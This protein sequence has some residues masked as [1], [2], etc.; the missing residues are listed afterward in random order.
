MHTMEDVVNLQIKLKSPI[1]KN[2]FLKSSKGEFFLVS[3]IGS[4]K[5]DMKSLKKQ[6]DVSDLRFASEEELDQYLGL[7]PGSVSIFGLI[8]L[9]VEKN[10]IVVLDSDLYESAYVAF[11]PNLNTETV[12]LTHENFIKYWDKI[13]LP[14]MILE[15]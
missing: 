5:L 9:P 1:P 8:N 10:L 6:F 15:I 2:L 12:E 14:K 4:K 7:K 3:M 11:H 13:D